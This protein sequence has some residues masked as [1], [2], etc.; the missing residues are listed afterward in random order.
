MANDD[1]N[2]ATKRLG[3]YARVSGKMG[4]LAA[5]L[6]GE[7]FLG[8]KIDRDDHARVLKEALGGLRGPLMKVAQLLSTV[9]DALPPEYA[10]ELQELQAQAPPMGWP[11]VRRRMQSEL[12]AGWEAKF[13]DF[14][15]TAQAAASLGQV[16]KAVTASGETVACKLQ[17]PDMSSAVE[18]DLKQL[19]MLFSMYEAYDKALQTK[20]VI[21]EIAMRLREELD[22]EREA[23]NTRAYA[24]MLANEAHVHVPTVLPDL[25]S[26]RLLT[27]S[28]LDGKP[29]LD[30]KKAPL[31]TRNTLALNLFRAWYVPLYHYGI[32]HGDPH[33]GNY[34]VRENLDINLLDF[35]CVRVFPVSFIK[36]ILDLYQALMKDD[37]ALTV[38]AFEAWGFRNLN[39]ELIDA[40]TTWARFLFQAV[41]DDRVRIIGRS[42][43]TV[44]GRETAMKVYQ[45][46]RSHGGISIP[47]EFVFMD[48]AALGL[49]SVFIHLQAEINWHQV[50]EDLTRDFDLETL[51]KRQADL[52][53]KYD[54]VPEI[55]SV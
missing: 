30:F 27:S 41:L 29:I 24:D 19:K 7:R 11:F 22:Y 31:E 23:K 10:R 2:T 26:K 18:A 3:R 51:Q 45:Q 16:H 46:L 14:P 9:P 39:N 36:G 1:K 33:P 5:K 6:A 47:R 21:D 40:L 28:W 44:Y 12:G 17:Y 20:H 53:S 35:G 55:T 13:T 4:G 34:T 42:E 49:G 54:I 37:R 50:F 38:H 15:K 43:G 48:R 25:S 8:M 52:L 32:V